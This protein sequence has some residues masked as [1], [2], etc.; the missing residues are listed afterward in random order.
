MRRLA[1]VLV[2][3]GGGAALVAGGAAIAADR[4]RGSSIEGFGI[5]IEL[6]SGWEG[7]IT[8]PPGPPARQLVASNAG[9]PE[10]APLAGRLSRNGAR[11]VLWDYGGN[12]CPPEELLPIVSRSDLDDCAHG[13]FGGIGR[14]H[15]T[16]SYSF[17]TGGRLFQLVAIFAGSPTDELLH[18]VNALLRTLEVEPLVDEVS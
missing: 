4:D 15:L 10:D 3:L 16:A 7:R 2:A 5:S 13:C 8:R 1:A 14:G 11:F 17:V 9:L 12:L 6:G 18:E